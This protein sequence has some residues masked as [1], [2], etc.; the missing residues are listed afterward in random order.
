MYNYQDSYDTYITV[1]YF[2]ALVFMWALLFLNIIV[3]ILF[4]NYEEQEEGQDDDTKELE[5]EAEE[6][7]IPEEIREII[8]HQDLVLGKC[9]VSGN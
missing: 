9:Q 7:G 6:I 3:A 2:L 1:V 5:Q 8:I 4:D